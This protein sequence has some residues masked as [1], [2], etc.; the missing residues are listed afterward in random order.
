MDSKDKTLGQQ[1]LPQQYS[2]VRGEEDRGT[3][4][5]QR[6]LR[7][8]EQDPSPL[9]SQVL[10]RVPYLDHNCDPWIWIW[11]W[12]WKGPA[13]AFKCFGNGQKERETRNPRINTH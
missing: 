4:K 8:V 12:I 3:L 7:K 13:A 10:M 9:E 5:Y 11:I 6:R 1:H 2:L